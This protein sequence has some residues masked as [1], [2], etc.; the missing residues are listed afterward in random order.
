M[1]FA[2]IRADGGVVQRFDFRFIRRGGGDLGLC[3]AVQVVPRI[4]GDGEFRPLL[5]AR[6]TDQFGSSHAE[7]II[8]YRQGIGFF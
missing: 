3:V 7:A 4:E 2:K 8:G 6:F 5:C 1:Q